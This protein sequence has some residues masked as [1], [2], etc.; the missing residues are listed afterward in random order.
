MPGL[1]LFGKR[2]FVMRRNHNKSYLGRI[3]NISEEKKKRFSSICSIGNGGL[4]HCLVNCFIVWH[5]RH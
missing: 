1:V 2:A 4:G 3:K 5:F